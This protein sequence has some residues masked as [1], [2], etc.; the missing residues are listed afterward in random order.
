[1]KSFGGKFHSYHLGQPCWDGMKKIRGWCFTS[2]Y[3]LGSYCKLCICS[4]ENSPLHKYLKV[5]KLVGGFRD[6]SGWLT[7]Y[8]SITLRWQPLT[9]EHSLPGPQVERCACLSDL[10]F[11]FT[12]SCLWYWLSHLGIWFQ[13][14]SQCLPW[15][16]SLELYHYLIPFFKWFLCALRFHLLGRFGIWSA[17]RRE[18]TLKENHF[19]EKVN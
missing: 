16:I 14:F 4:I 11:T 19:S 7:I 9:Q 3:P 17:L 8:W 2:Y 1:M 12:H 15:I 6:P 10:C 5:I 18:L 13:V